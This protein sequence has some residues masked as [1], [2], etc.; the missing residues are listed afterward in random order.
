MNKVDYLNEGYRQL[1]DPVFYREI[2]RN[3]TNKHTTE[4]QRFLQ[5]LRQKKLLPDAHITFITPRNCRTPLFYLLPKIHKKNN[6]GRPIVS[7]CD[8]PTEKMSMYLDSFLQPLAQKVDSCIKDTTHFLS[9][10]S[11]LGQLDTNS[12]LVTIDVVSLYTNIPHRDGILATKAALETRTT[13]EPKT[14]VLLRLLHFILTKTAFKFNNKF[15]EQISGTTMGTKCAPSY[16]IIFLGKLEKDFLLTSDLRPILWWRYIDD[17]F[18]IWP[19]SSEELNSFLEALNSCHPTIKFTSTISETSV[20]FLDVTVI[21][22]QNGH[23]H[24]DLYTKPTDA[25][26]YLHYTSFHPKH[27]KRSLPYSQALRLRRICSSTD[28]FIEATRKMHANF[29]ARG[30]PSQLVT[31]AITQALNQDRNSLLIQT[32]H[33]TAEIS[34]IPFIVTYN[35]R[36]PPIAKILNKYKRLLQLSEDLKP[37]QNSKILVV[38][39]RAVNLKQTLVKTDLNPPTIDPGSGPCNKPCNTCRFMKKTT[40][41]TS[42]KTKQTLNIK[43]NFNCQTKNIVYVISCAKCGVQYVGQSGNTFNERLRGHLADIRQGNNFKPVPRHFTSS[44]H[45][46]DDVTATIV[47]QTHNNVNFR[48]RTEETWINTLQTKHPSGL[49]LIL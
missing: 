7:A 27:Q 31:S 17:I 12:L 32:P 4:I 25:H 1:N 42:W 47:T 11:Q 29:T 41:I 39:K 30:Y 33:P 46:S 5:T 36:N 13:K 44:N 26:L 35:P 19:H 21:K 49:N 16:A 23:L 48:L 43:G 14:W 9:N 10:L 8:S 3:P 37:I 15:Y 38:H 40:K 20:N 18:M 22:D 45:T 28:T 34:T 24:T 2:Q 6:P